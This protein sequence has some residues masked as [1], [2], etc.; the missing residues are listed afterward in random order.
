M[1]D[2]IKCENLWRCRAV[3]WIHNGACTVVVVHEHHTLQQITYLFL[4]VILNLQLMDPH[5]FR[6]KSLL[7]DVYL[8]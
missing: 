6:H 5:Y 7:S 2:S 1:V 8:I 3:S 4:L